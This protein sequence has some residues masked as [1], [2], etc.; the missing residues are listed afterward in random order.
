MSK[1]LPVAL[2]FQSDARQIDEQHP[3]ASSRATLY[4]LVALIVCAIGWAYVAT[5]DRVVV[6]PG[7]LVA[8]AATIIVQPL[9]TSVVRSLNA[10]I[11]DVVHKGDPLATLDPTFSMADAAQLRGKMASLDAQIARLDAR[12]PIG[13]TRQN[14]ST[15]RRACS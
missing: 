8:T 10:R 5:V 7:K 6:A 1:L 3:P 11:G 15:T 14:W 4:T 2:E 13:H 12:S 9:E